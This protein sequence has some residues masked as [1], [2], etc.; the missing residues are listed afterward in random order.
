MCLQEPETGGP[1]SYLLGSGGIGEKQDLDGGC[2][3]GPVST[4]LNTTHDHT[5]TDGP[6][7]TST[8]TVHLL[9]PTRVPP[10]HAKLTM[11]NLEGKDQHLLLDP[12]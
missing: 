1:P 2:A 5:I 7:S 8:Q 3:K 9:R 11:I 4:Q 10:H 6:N 12:V